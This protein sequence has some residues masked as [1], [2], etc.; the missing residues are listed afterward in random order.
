MIRFPEG[1]SLR[2]F[3]A[4]GAKTVPAWHYHPEFELAFV[5]RGR[6]WRFVGDRAEP[7]D[8]GDLVL[9][10]PDLPHAWSGEDSRL[11]A[12][13]PVRLRA[14]FVQFRERFLGRE[15]W[16]VPEFAAVDGLLRRSRQGVRFTGPDAQQAGERLRR[17]VKLDGAER[18]T[19]LLVV[20]DLLAH[21]PG[22]ILLSSPTYAP[23][24]DRADAARL[25]AVCRYIRTHLTRKKSQSV[26]AALV[27]LSPERFSDFFQ[28]KVGSTFPAYVNEL[29][30]N[31]AVQ[32]MIERRMSIAEAC[33]AS[34]FNNL[35]N[36]NQQFRA[37]KGLSPREYLRRKAH[38]GQRCK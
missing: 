5:E 7:F 21:S 16:R 17:L 26:A 36:F 14:I 10:G 11:D 31:H 37:R 29:R 32:L 18:V 1:D 9:L 23:R 19:G 27:R 2:L 28:E 4:A 38:P 33:F 22:Q 25:K 24:L 6:G 3:R 8:E 30:I 34:G 15:L 13:K 20:L 35:S 12:L